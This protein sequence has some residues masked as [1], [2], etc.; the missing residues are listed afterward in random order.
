MRTPVL[1]MDANW[2][3]FKKQKNKNQKTNVEL[4]QRH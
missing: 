1:G 4:T 3:M 2:N